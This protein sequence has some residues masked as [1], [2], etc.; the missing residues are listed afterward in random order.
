MLSIAIVLFI[1]MFPVLI[2]A[3]VSTVG[4]ISDARKRR[5]ERIALPLGR[6]AESVA[7]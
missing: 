5:L 1:I 6:Y 3:A 2:P 7:R 4:A